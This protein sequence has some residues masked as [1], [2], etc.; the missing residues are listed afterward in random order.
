[1]SKYDERRS[2]ASRTALP[3]VVMVAGRPAM[4]PAS[5]TVWAVPDSYFEI[6]VA[7]VSHKKPNLEPSS[8]WSMWTAQDEYGL[9]AEPDTDA[10]SSTDTR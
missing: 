9:S 5:R 10:A 3:V 2:R 1:M 7:S 8:A 6:T 4:I